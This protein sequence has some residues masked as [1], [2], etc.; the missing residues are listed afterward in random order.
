MVVENSARGW[1]GRAF[2]PLAFF[3]W[4][5]PALQGAWWRRAAVIMGRFPPG[6]FPLLGPPV[7]GEAEGGSAL[8]LEA[9]PQFAF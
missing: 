8:R 5:T 1:G 9:I 4:D 7:D 2:G 6:L 3:L